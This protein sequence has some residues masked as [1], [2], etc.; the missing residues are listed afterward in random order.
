MKA[1]VMFSLCLLSACSSELV[2]CERHLTPINPP[3]AHLRDS[4]GAARGEGAPQPVPRSGAATSKAGTTVDG[5]T[6]PSRAPGGAAK[7]HGM[8]PPGRGTP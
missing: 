8:M 7:A 6:G 3:A 1:A 4:T 2:R 5:K